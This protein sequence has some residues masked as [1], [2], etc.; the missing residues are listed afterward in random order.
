MNRTQELNTIATAAGLRD[1]DVLKIAKVD[2]LPKDAV[3]DLMRRFPGAFWALN[4]SQS[5]QFEQPRPKQYAQMTQAEQDEF[6][7]ANRLP[8]KP[9]PPRRHR[10]RRV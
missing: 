5:E 4:P 7:R 8:T 3:H 10:S 9:L 6:N 1:P 2:L